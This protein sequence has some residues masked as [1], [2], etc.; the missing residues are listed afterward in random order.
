MATAT[1][2]DNLIRM[3]ATGDVTANEL[4]YHRSCLNSFHREY[5]GITKQE[6]REKKW[7]PQVPT[8]PGRKALC[9]IFPQ[10]NEESDLEG[11][12][13]TWKIFLI[14]GPAR[15]YRRYRRKRCTVEKDLCPEQGVLLLHV[16]NT[17]IQL[18]FSR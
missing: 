5:E 18:T 15:T 11:N 7:V 9:S 14:F 16:G 1:Q 13:G 6:H 17:K 12:F 4:F 3:L 2:N 10:L 8:V